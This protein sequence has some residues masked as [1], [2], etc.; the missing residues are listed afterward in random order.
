LR[1]AHCRENPYHLLT[2]WVPETEP[3]VLRHEARRQLDLVASVGCTTRDERLSLTL[4]DADRTAATSLLERAGIAD[5]GKWALFHPGASAA[6]RRY[7]GELY[8]RAADR[9]AGEGWRII[10]SGGS[11]EIELV[12]SIQQAMAG[13]STSFAGRLGLAQ[14][15]AVIERAP[16]LVSN[17]TAPVHMAAALGTP[18]VDLYALTNPQHTPWLVASRV[19]NR[20]V[21]CRNCYKSACPQGHHDCLRLVSPE[22]VAAAAMELVNGYPRRPPIVLRPRI[23][24]EM[25][26]ERAS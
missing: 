26:G 16:V 19:L 6:S 1:L 4:S 13:E 25:G 2:D 20:D 7:P 11:G 5:G 17:N 9:L 24:Q 23:G 3:E 10:F 22:E 15:G 21:P 18:V 14:L 12:E 8:A